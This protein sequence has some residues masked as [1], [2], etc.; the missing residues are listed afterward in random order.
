MEQQNKEKVTINDKAFTRLMITSLIGFL[1]CVACLCSTT[2]AWFSDNAPSHGNEI[3]M[4][5]KFLL[6]V[7]VAGEGEPLEGIENG[8][9]LSAGV[10][11]TV[12]LT[13]PAES[14]SG[15]CIL[16]AGG[17]QYYTDYLTAHESATPK[18]TSFTLKVNSDQTVVFTKH[19]GIYHLQECA[20]R[21]GVLELP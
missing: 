7:S 11:Y 17:T 6:T 5:D 16:T 1:V 12:T 14:A 10:E 13:L 21:N 8:V 2:W 4:A 20:V 18:V 15:Y 19:W 9:A 3:K